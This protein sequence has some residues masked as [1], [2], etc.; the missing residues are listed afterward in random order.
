MVLTK[1]EIIMC[2][3]AIL[4]KTQREVD[5]IKN[6][7]VI[8]SRERKPLTL[9]EI[10]RFLGGV[11]V[12]E[13]R[14]VV[15]KNPGHFEWYDDGERYVKIVTKVSICEV[16]CSKN[17]TCPGTIPMCTGLHICKF[18]LLSG[19]CQYGG[20]CSFGHDLTISH[21]MKILKEN[22]LDGLSVED[23]KYLFGQAESRTSVTAPKICKFYNVE[24]GCRY[25]ESGKPCPNLHICKHYVSSSC[26][27]GKK[28][29][30]SHDILNH[31]VKDILEKHG[32]STRRTPKEILTD[33]REAV[34]NAGNDGSSV[35][36][37]SLNTGMLGLSLQPRSQA[38]NS[39]SE[40]SDGS[41]IGLSHQKRGS[42]C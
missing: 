35:G 19:K 42:K 24:A 36:S 7:N 37:F 22:Y 20:Q 41:G 10:S 14:N 38:G 9:Q 2:A 3:Y 25:A 1:T 17:R 33:L 11:Q 5:I 8:L 27:F 13:L 26:R 31:S 34:S 23:L 28:C 39:S 32:I 16:H 12:D 18:Y 15:F 4:P 40:D 29:R 30:R 21:N 6:V